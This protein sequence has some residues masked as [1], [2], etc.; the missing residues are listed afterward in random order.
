MTGSLEGEL[1]EDP[2][3]KLGTNPLELNH[4]K[5][6][7][8]DARNDPETMGGGIQI[9]KQKQGKSARAKG[10]DLS[11]R[12]VKFLQDQGYLAVRVDFTIGGGYAPVQ[13]VDMMGFA[14]VMGFK[15]YES[16]GVRLKFIQST[17]KEQRTAHERKLCDSVRR[18]PRILRSPYDLACEALTKGAEIDF[19]LWSKDGSRWVV[20]VVPITLEWLQERKAKLDARRAA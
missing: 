4:A 14:D 15:Y 13:A 1:F 12:S 10:H 18:V 6:L 5:K 7:I 11:N 19:H 17:T 2:F 16:G 3:E 20:E 8:E 9:G